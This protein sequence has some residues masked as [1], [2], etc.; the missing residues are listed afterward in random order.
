MLGTPYRPPSL[1][2]F[3]PPEIEFFAVSDD[4]E[5]K[6]KIFWCQNISGL[7]KLKKKIKM[8]RNHPAGLET[9]R[10]FPAGL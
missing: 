5:Q 6:E 8:S 2:K 4:F 3:G 1:L 10:K 9:S 7:E